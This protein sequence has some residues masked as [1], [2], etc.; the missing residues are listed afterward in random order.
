M[1]NTGSHLLNMTACL[2]G[3][4]PHEFAKP[5]HVQ[6]ELYRA[7]ATEGEDT[8]CLR[9][10]TDTGVEVCIHLAQCATAGHPPGFFVIGEK[11]VAV[12]HE[13]GDLILSEE[14]VELPT[15]EDPYAELLRRLVEVIAGSDEPLLMPLAESEGY[16][17]LSNGAYESA[18]RIRPIPPE[19]TPRAT[20]DGQ[21]PSART[22]AR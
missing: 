8:D 18:G 2:A 20:V 4:E 15:G 9:A 14:H 16:V 11:A 21:R 6:G 19:Y 13:Q 22:M 12:F 5:L 7:S 3:T 10:Q 1:N 17:L